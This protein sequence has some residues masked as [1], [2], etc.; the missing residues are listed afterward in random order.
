[1]VPIYM[2]Q[3]LQYNQQNIDNPSNATGPYKIYV[4]SL[5]KL[6]ETNTPVVDSQMSQILCDVSPRTDTVI[7]L[8]YDISFE[9]DAILS[10]G[11]AI[12]ITTVKSPSIPISANTIHVISSLSSLRLQTRRK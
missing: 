4:F 2:K 1:M 10:T 3:C 5:L 12:P 6:R 7:D 8:T 9:S 11:K